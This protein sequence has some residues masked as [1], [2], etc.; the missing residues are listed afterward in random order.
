MYFAWFSH[1]L[2]VFQ[3]LCFSDILL[4]SDMFAVLLNIL[5]VLIDRI[6]DRRATRPNSARV[7]AQHLSRLPF[8][9][10]R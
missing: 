4:F 8:G 2:L 10:R 3:I 5:V 6:S 1:I 7:S 9:F